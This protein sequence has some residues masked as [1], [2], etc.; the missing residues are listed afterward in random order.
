M[1][2]IQND[3][4]MANL[5]DVLA[6]GIPRALE[7]G[8]GDVNPPGVKPPGGVVYTQETLGALGLRG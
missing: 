7:N 6:D 3:Q 1:F 8:S 5:D 4:I 2:R